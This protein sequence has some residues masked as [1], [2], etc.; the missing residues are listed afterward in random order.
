MHYRIID[1]HILPSPGD[2]WQWNY[3]YDKCKCVSSARINSIYLHRFRVDECYEKRIYIC[4]YIYILFPD[5]YL[6]SKVSTIS[7]NCSMNPAIQFTLLLVY[8]ANWDLCICLP[9]VAMFGSLTFR[10]AL[11][12]IEV[13]WGI[14]EIGVFTKTDSYF[15]HQ[16]TH[17]YVPS[18]IGAW[19]G[20]VRYG[21]VC[22]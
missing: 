10:F 19:H 11:V 13:Y 7:N 3:V 22:V 6:E 9:F 12:S 8:F 1:I 18:C 20:T 2:K 14:C 17:S 15:K 16:I 4:I 21:M 5:K